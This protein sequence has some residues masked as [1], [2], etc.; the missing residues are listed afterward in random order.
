M[1]IKGV[2]FAKIEGNL[3]IKNETVAFLLSDTL[4]DSLPTIIANKQPWI[5][6]IKF[7]NFKF[8]ATTNFKSYTDS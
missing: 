6:R 8:R 4:S 2:V 7:T 5:F 3:L 1:I